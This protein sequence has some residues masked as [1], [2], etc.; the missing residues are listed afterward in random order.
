VVVALSTIEAKYI[1]VGNAG[2]S[3]VHVRQLMHDV[4]QR[5]HGATTV[6]EDTKGAMKLAINPMASNMTDISTSST[7]TFGNW[8]MQGQSRLCQ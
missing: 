3:A 6:Y 1:A 7:T 8:W 4:H 5:Q 2:Q